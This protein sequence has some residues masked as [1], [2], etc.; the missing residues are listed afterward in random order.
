MGPGLR[1]HV[2]S[3][4]AVFLALGVGMVIGSSQLQGAIVDRLTTQIKALNQ[5]YA[6]EVAPLREEQQRRRREV[7]ALRPRILRG[8][9]KDTHVAIVVTGDYPDLV[10][11]VRAALEEAGAVVTGVANV[12]PDVEERYGVHKAT[13]DPVLAALAPGSQPGLPAVW[14]VLAA[15]LTHPENQALMDGLTGTDLVSL[16]G[17]FSS[18]CRT[19]VIIGG[20]TGDREDRSASVDGDLIAGL[21]SLGVRVAGVEPTTAVISYV[22]VFSRQGAASIDNIDTDTGQIC[23]PLA[24]TTDPGDY[25]IKRTARGG[26]FPPVSAQP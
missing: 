5:R 21:R 24:L 8:V 22:P 4:T 14:S 17:T 9:L 7:E 1:Y 2:V 11:P 23:L 20:A 16:N 13:I 15:A 10:Q 12:A 3:L 18:P 6:A 26:A 19:V 25:G